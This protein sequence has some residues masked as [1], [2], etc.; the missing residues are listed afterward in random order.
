M[1]SRIRTALGLTLLLTALTFITVFAKGSFSFITITG[2]DLKE[3]I[4]STD[5]ALTT[6]FFAFADFFQDK[7]TEPA[8]PG[9]GYEITRYYV[10][11]GRESA[12]DHLHYYPDSGYVFYDGIVNGWSEYDNEWYTA[13][14]EIKTAFDR[15]LGLAPMVKTEPQPSISQPMG[16]NALTV[17]SSP[18]LK[19]QSV[20]LVS[21][22][23]GL[24]VLLLLVYWRR[25]SLAR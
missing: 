6:D 23:T 14:P 7:I 3:L 15:A 9:A 1:L 4:R 20:V 13:S 24:A 10:D 22:A 16:S 18:F 17:S 2:P 19:S 5:P 25:R 11:G 21:V 8:D 12:F